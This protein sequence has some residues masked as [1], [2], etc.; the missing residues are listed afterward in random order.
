MFWK[1]KTPSLHALELELEIK[2]LKEGILLL[3]TN[4]SLM[5][6]GLAHMVRHAQQCNMV[7]ENH[8]NAIMALTK[9]AVPD[10]KLSIH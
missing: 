2:N 10:D 1:T 8:A 4:I 3:Q 7:M 5:E 6:E 9:N